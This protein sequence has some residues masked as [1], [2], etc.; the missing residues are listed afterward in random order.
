M[1]S[2]EPHPLLDGDLFMADGG[3]ET[4]LVFGEGIEL[5]AF[6]AFGLLRGDEG[7][8]L[9]RG[10]YERYAGLARELR[11]GM[12]LQAP[13][14]RA[15]PRWAAGL[16]YSPEAVVALNRR[17]VALME[18]TRDRLAAPEVPMVVGASIASADDA[19]RPAS[20]MRPAEAE[21]H[22]A[23]QIAILRDTSAKLVTAMT[24]TYAD[25]A[26]GIADAAGRAGMPVA[27]SFTLETD[28]RLP[29]GEGLGE[30]ILR[31]DDA[32]GG[33]PVHYMVNCVHPSHL[34]P[35]LEAGG[36]WRERIGGL[37]VNASTKSHAELD[38]ARELDQ[39]DVGD[40]AAGC[41]AFRELLPGI[42]LLGGCCG[43]DERHVR[44][45]VERW[46]EAPG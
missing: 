33:L 29:S 41:A 9:L 46:R 30:A 27:I 31:V 17:A 34:A 12:L 2:A 11:V 18:E 7:T 3:L 24:L 42:R 36:D 10:Y 23:A 44:A 39:G 26:I 21:R 37:R 16:G 45:I 5:P 35:V 20:R 1:A 43:T 25:E 4:T 14:W 22:H 15:S 13:T 6:A 38:G 28:G 19:Y 40:L 8:A 32:T